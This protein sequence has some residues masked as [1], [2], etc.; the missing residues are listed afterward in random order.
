MKKTL[1]YILLWLLGSFNASAASYTFN[2]NKG[3]SF[4]WQYD[5]VLGVYTTKGTRIKHWALADGKV[6]PF[7]SYGWSLVG[8]CKYYLYY[9]FNDSYF[10]SDIPI[11]DLPITFEGQVQS[12]NNSLSH[13]AAYDYMI[14]EGN[15]AE[16]SADF[17]MI[18][19]CSVIRIEFVSPKSAVYTNVALK[20][21]DRLFCQT[22]DMNLETQSINPKVKKSYANLMLDNIAVEEGEKLVAYMVV[23]PVDLS[24]WDVK[25]V[26]SSDDDKEIEFNV[27]ANNLRAGKLYLLNTTG[28][29]EKELSTKHRAGSLA[30]PSVS[31]VDIPIDT[32]SEIIVTGIQQ[33]KYNQE[34]D[35][36]AV[37]TLSGIRTKQPSAKGV[38]IKNRKK[39]LSPRPLP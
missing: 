16:T 31:V 23:A 38:I 33:T 28:I 18:H 22:A 27:Q 26:F 36:D 14:G 3:I 32:D 4:S 12:K 17:N 2:I 37:Y 20:V 10:Q 19:T 39:F 1:S 21:T 35:D 15:T 7:S 24:G 29:E 13:L 11:T 8:N 30:E 6:T 34:R 5:D 9:P 25:L